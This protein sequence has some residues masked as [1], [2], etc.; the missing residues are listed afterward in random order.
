MLMCGKGKGL[1]SGR[2]VRAEP[3][4]R[5]LRANI[6]PGVAASAKIAAT[7]TRLSVLFKEYGQDQQTTKQTTIMDR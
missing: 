2:L 3:S 1:V 6:M 5:L 4:S 7:L